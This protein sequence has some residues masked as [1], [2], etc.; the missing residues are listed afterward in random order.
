MEQR[1][2]RGNMTDMKEELKWLK[3]SSESHQNN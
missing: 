3:E 2:N 1:L